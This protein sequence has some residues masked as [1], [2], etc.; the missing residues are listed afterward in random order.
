MVSMPG[1]HPGWLTYVGVNDIQQS[2]DQA[3]SLGAT[4]HMGPQEI[5]NIGWMT[6][7]QDPTGCTIAIFQPK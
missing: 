2:T 3:R 7:L 6:I 1:G 4:I 5:P